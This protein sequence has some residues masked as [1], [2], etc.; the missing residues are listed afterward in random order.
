MCR[1]YGSG[2]GVRHVH[3]GRMYGSGGGVVYWGLSEHR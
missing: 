2:G 3:M 1:M